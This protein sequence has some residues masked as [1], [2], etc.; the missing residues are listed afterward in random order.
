VKTAFLV[1]FLGLCFTTVAWVS[2][3][4]YTPDIKIP[5][6]DD[7]DF[8]KLVLGGLG[9][10]WSFFGGIQCFRHGKGMFGKLLA[11][12]LMLFGMLASAALFALMLWST[13]QIPPPAEVNT[14]K[15]APEFT[16]RDANGK[17]VAL[18][19]FRG[20]RVVLIFARGMW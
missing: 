14:G 4:P 3:Q 17:E 16:L 10:M 8:P 2:A 15:P 19:G 20:K 18:T 11:G 5:V 13:R 6:I 9:G 1:C 7:G 12:M